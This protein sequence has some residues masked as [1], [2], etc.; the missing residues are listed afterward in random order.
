MPGWANHIGPTG[1]TRRHLNVYA[2][3]RAESMLFVVGAGIEILVE[4]R[5]PVSRR[6]AYERV[7]DGFHKAEHVACRHRHVRCGL[8]RQN[9]R[10]IAFTR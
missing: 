7:F 4:M 10:G 8:E 3:S 5:L 6:F 1:R 2:V 9:A